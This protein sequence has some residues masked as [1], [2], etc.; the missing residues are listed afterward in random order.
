MEVDKVAISIIRDSN[1]LT[2]QQ[3]VSD[4]KQIMEGPATISQVIPPF[5]SSKDLIIVWETA[6]SI[7]II[8]HKKELQ[9]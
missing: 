8:L 2:L 5:I 3:V 7:N 4:H 1:L 9:V 6:N